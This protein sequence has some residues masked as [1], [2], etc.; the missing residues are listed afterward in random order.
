MVTFNLPINIDTAQ[1]AGSSVPLGLRSLFRVSRSHRADCLCYL[2]SSKT[3]LLSNFISKFHTHTMDFQKHAVKMWCPDTPATNRYTQG[4][5]MLVSSY[6]WSGWIWNL[7]SLPITTGTWFYNLP[8]DKIQAHQFY[9]S[10]H[11]FQKLHSE[12]HFKALKNNYL[13]THQMKSF[14]RMLETK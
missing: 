7:K 3:Y 13:V 8:T 1:P 2:F 12:W 11:P 10:L 9:C 5:T 6:R 14:W 4:R